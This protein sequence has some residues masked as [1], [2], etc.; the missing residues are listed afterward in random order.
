MPGLVDPGAARLKLTQL[1]AVGIGHRRAAHLAGVAVSTV[2]GIRAGARPHIRL[3][4]EQAI[5]GIVRPS[6]AHGQRVNGYRTRC[7]LAALHSEGYRRGWIAQR[8]GLHRCQLW[9][10][11][12][13][14]TVEK[15][16]KV[17]A[18]YVVVTAEP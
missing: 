9:R 3:R 5:L 14:V 1:S 11:A 18:L 2:Q 15:A 13:S 10:H 17:R 6:L 4:V 7:Q 8:L 16:L 12:P